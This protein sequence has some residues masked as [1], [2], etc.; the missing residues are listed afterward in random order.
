MIP[1]RKLKAKK[2]SKKAAA[3]L[4]P[5][6]HFNFPTPARRR[7]FRIFDLPPELRTLVF[8][9]ATVRD[10][11]KLVKSRPRRAAARQAGSRKCFLDGLLVSKQWSTSASSCS[12]LRALTG[13]TSP[14]MSSMQ[15][16][17]TENR[18]PGQQH[19]LGQSS[20]IEAAERAKGWNVAL[21]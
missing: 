13:A 15:S 8:E 10:V 12:F 7:V 14:S 17:A 18:E 9:W 5:I 2:S 20:L 4:P 11:M 1:R 19:V 3:S 16:C 6:G 21:R